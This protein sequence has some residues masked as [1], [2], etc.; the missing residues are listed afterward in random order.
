MFIFKLQS[1]FYSMENNSQ[2][3]VHNSVSTPNFE[4][5]G[6]QSN[7]QSADSAEYGGYQNFKDQKEAYFSKKQNENASRPEYL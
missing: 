3:S 4:T 1:D 5:D 2:R 7:R 6:Y